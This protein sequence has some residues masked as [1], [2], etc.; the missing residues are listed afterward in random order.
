MFLPSIRCSLRICL[1][2]SQAW[3]AF[4][5]PKVTL[6][7]VKEEIQRLDRLGMRFAHGALDGF[8]NLLCP[9]LYLQDMLRSQIFEAD[10]IQSTF[11]P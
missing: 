8:G 6:D 7:G 10:Y 4:K 3:E 9:L 1:S 11:R 5:A 2:A